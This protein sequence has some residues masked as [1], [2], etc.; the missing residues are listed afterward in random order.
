MAQLNRIRSWL[1]AFS[2][3]VGEDRQRAGCG[4]KRAAGESNVEVCAAWERRMW[5][6]LSVEAK[7]PCRAYHDDVMTK[8]ERLDDARESGPRA[9]EFE[10][11]QRGEADLGG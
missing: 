4:R 7:A 6:M 9:T 5:T 11:L 10:L 1:A 2:A 3:T 8:I